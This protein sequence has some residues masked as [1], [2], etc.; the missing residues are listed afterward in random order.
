MNGKD[1]SHLA[2]HAWTCG[3]LLTGA[4]WAWGGGPAFSGIVAESTDP[5]TIMLELAYHF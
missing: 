5:Y 2:G 3:I 1:L 4:S